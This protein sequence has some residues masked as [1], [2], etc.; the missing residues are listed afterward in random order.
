MTVFLIG[1]YKLS[2][3]VTSSVAPGKAAQGRAVKLYKL[4]V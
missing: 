1:R 3:A 4:I 2:V